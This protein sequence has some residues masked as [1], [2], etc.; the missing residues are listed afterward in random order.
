MR[1]WSWASLL[2]LP[3]RCWP[4]HLHRP[5]GIKVRSYPGVGEGVRVGGLWA[6][7][8]EVMALNKQ[9]ETEA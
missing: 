3:A 7:L 4:S 9:R 2:L 6:L 5:P 8:L 1:Q